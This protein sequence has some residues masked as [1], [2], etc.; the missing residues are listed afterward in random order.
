MK[1][2]VTGASGHVGTNLCRMLIEKGYHVK[3]LVHRDVKG[4]AGLP[5][6]TIKGDIRNTEDLVSL[7]TDCEVVFNLAACISIHKNDKKC[8]SLNIESCRNLIEAARQTGVKRIIHFSSIHAFIQEPFDSEL[9]ETRPLA[10]DSTTAY[11]HSK[12]Q[13]QQMM[14]DASLHGPEI[15]ILNPTSIIGPNDFKPSLVGSA[16]IRFY[17]GQNPCLIPGGYDWVDVRDVCKAAINAIS[18]GSPGE[19]YLLSGSWRDLRTMAGEIE[20]LGGHKAP[21]IRLPMWIAFFGAFFLNLHARLRRTVPLYTS[22]SLL[23]LKN[24]HRNI[25]CQKAKSV[26]DYDPR[27]F[28][29][30][31]HDTIKWFNE[32]KY[33]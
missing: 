27:S 30:T 4:L 12:A 31:I 13:S 15:V 10:L 3:V 21:S 33:I 23:T 29:E 9:N 16:L 24:S 5:I 17:K 28:E 14:K 25:S 6:E 7:C 11:E 2:A 18:K 1:I 19:C 8:D 26:L 32:N 22:V 20:K